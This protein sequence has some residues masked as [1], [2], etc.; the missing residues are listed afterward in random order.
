MNKESILKRGNSPKVLNF[1]LETDSFDL[2][3]YKLL[4][5]NDTTKYHEYLVPL[6]KYK[7][8]LDPNLEVLNQCTYGWKYVVP[9][10]ISFDINMI[11]YYLDN[12]D[13]YKDDGLSQLI[14]KKSNNKI[15]TDNNLLLRL[16]D[17]KY[18]NTLKNI[19][20]HYKTS[21]DIDLVN[22]LVDFFKS[23]KLRYVCWYTS[24][25]SHE[26]LYKYMEAFKYFSKDTLM[27]NLHLLNTDEDIDNFLKVW[28]KYNLDYDYHLISDSLMKKNKQLIKIYFNIS[29]IIYMDPGTIKLIKNNRNLWSYINLNNMRCDINFYNHHI[30]TQ[31]DLILEGIFTF[32]KNPN[33][34][35]SYRS[36]SNAVYLLISDILL[37]QVKP[38]KNKL[39]PLRDKVVQYSQIIRADIKEFME[40]FIKLLNNY[41]GTKSTDNSNIKSELP[42]LQD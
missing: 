5:Q 24:F 22:K 8:N 29:K 28:N 34:N 1:I 30:K 16:I 2:E 23:E 35:T 40:E 3:D 27:E 37:S 39:E 36:T 21:L 26:A 33:N 4:V 11:D 18:T 31:Y 14:E 7:F 12:P 15:I 19:L 25:V 38:D 42:I 41:I 6:I 13:E 20:N 10:Y 17:M 9:K 32:V